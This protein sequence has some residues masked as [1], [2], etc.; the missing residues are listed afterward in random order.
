MKWGVMH[1]ITTK[2]PPCRTR[3][4]TSLPLLAE[5]GF[6]YGTPVWAIPQQDGF[7]ISMHE[8]SKNGALMHVGLMNNKPSLMINFSKNFYPAGLIGGD[9]LAAKFDCGTIEAKKLPA[10]QKYYV[11]GSQNR[12][13]F[14]QFSGA[15]LSDAGFM[16][17]A[18]VTVS[19]FDEGIIF[20]VWNDM[21]ESYK[22]FVKFARSDKCQIIQPRKNQGIITLDIPAYILKSASFDVGDISGVHYEYGL[23]KLFKP[24]LRKIGF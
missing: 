11:I 7:T 12:N 22:D 1:V 24:D 23:I 14:L 16:P 21:T 13:V 4:K 18:V 17:D 10:A 20:R 5:M 9:F 19:V 8:N 6:V 2:K 15:W 3:V